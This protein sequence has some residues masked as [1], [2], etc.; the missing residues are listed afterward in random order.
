MAVYMVTWNLNNERSNYDQ[1]RRAFITHLERYDN[2]QDGGLESVR[3]GSV[4]L[5]L[6]ISY[7]MIC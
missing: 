6:P 4:P 3:W 1:A 7:P 5:A 2:C